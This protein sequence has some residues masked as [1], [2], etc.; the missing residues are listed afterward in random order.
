MLPKRD[1][2]DPESNESWAKGL[3]LFGVILGDVIGL[4]L[5]GALIGYGFWKKMGAPWLIM[6]AL[7]LVGMTFA[8]YRLYQMSKKE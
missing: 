7:G 1:S 8:F 6:P 4:P 5:A 3:G 2:R